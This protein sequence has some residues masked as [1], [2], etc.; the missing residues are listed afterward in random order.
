MELYLGWL[1][2]YEVEEGENSGQDHE[3]YLELKV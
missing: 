3:L 2:K 1:N